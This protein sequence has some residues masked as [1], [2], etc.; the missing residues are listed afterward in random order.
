M[1]GVLAGELHAHIGRTVVLRGWLHHQR[2]LS[3]VSF[4]LLRDRTGLVQVV[5]EEEQDRQLAAILGAETVLELEGAVVGNPQAP[6]GVEV[7]LRT[8]RVLAEPEGP[9]P[10][11]LRRQV[12]PAAL[13]T[14]LDHAA[15][16][17]RHPARRAVANLA[18][19]ASHGFRHSLEQLGFTEKNTPKV[20]G[21]ATEGGAEVFAVDWF[22][23]S[24][25]LAQSPQFYKQTMVGALE[26]VYEVGP[27]F[28]AEPHDTARHLAEYVS[29]DAEMG[30]IRD[31]RDV[32]S[33]LRQV[34]AGMVS[35]TVERAGSALQLLG[36]EPPSVPEEIPVVTSLRPRR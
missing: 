7:Q 10:F 26:R 16:Y 25:Y 5:I 18:A 8:L 9:P 31:H 30:F 14:L 4:L 34:L 33:V 35:A 19:A 27:V 32:M 21:S 23:R 12:I 29:L 13:P 36:T 15:I 22:G 17:L 2:R 24:A 28:R 20:V 1:E 11:E 6:G 3:R